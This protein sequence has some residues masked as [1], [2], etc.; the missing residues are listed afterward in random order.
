MANSLRRRDILRVSGVVALAGTAGCLDGVVEELPEAENDSEEGADPTPDDGGTETPEEGGDDSDGNESDDVEP[1]GETD[2]EDDGLGET[3]DNETGVTGADDTNETDDSN[4]DGEGTDST[5]DEATGDGSAEGDDEDEAEDEREEDATGDGS[6]SDGDKKDDDGEIEGDD[7]DGTESSEDK[8]GE[9]ATDEGEEDGEDDTD[10][11]DAEGT[12]PEEPP[13]GFVTYANE[14]LGYAVVHPEGWT[15]EESGEEVYVGDP[16]SGRELG[17]LTFDAAPFD[18]SEA[19]AAE[20]LAGLEADY[21]D[22]E[23]REEGDRTLE[24]GEDARLLDVA[25]GD[26]EGERGRR[27]S[28]LLF[29]IDPRTDAGYVVEVAASAPAFSDE[30]AGRADTMLGSFRIEG[31]SAVDRIGRSVLASGTGIP[32]PTRP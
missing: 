29:V 10:E 26:L 7:S 20:F 28:Q 5:E 32:R 1:S 8:D 3:D 13:N 30:F 15:V 16:E 27:R 6:E 2:G 11:G 19:L 23:V 4:G 24:S 22:V 17:V 18:S 9:E 14:E 31:G 12:P 25:Y 21:E